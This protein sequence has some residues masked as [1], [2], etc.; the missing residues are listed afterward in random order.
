MVKTLI[1]VW[2]SVSAINAMGPVYNTI[3]NATDGPLWLKIKYENG[4]EQPWLV[5]P[6]QAI[7]Y[8][9]NK[10]E[11]ALSVRELKQRVVSEVEE[12][13]FEFSRAKNIMFNALKSYCIK[14]H[15][16]ELILCAGKNVDSLISPEQICNYPSLFVQN[17]SLNKLYFDICVKTKDDVKDNRQ[18]TNYQA[19]CFP[20][21]V[22]DLCSPAGKPIENVD[23]VLF[24]VRSLMLQGNEHLVADEKE[25]TLKL[26][27][28]KR[29]LLVYRSN[30]K[31][32]YF[33]VDT[34]LNCISLQ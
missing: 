27:K 2:L 29:T 3:T 20:G 32:E 9:Q 7:Y 22:V 12:S 19:F 5:L 15:A 33:I 18:G 16:D 24:T 23:H 10:Q 1:F 11:L 14:I 34:N 31:P 30:H 4:I 21:A 8:W 13:K 25:L 17:I 26:S 6:N 28:G